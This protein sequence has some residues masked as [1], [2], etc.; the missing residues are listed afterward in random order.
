MASEPLTIIPIEILNLLENFKLSSFGHSSTDHLHVLAE[1][2]K[3]AWAERRKYLADPGFVTVPT[4]ELTNKGYAQRRVSE[5]EME[6]R[7]HQRLRG[8]SHS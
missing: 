3:L 8:V 1:A 7:R 5:I 2:Q 4:K 6:R